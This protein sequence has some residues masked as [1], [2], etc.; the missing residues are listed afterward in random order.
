MNRDLI[1]LALLGSRGGYGRP[2]G[3]V[4]GIAIGV[5]LLVFMLLLW[6]CTTLQIAQQIG[7]NV[8][9]SIV[10]TIPSGPWLHLWYLIQVCAS[11][12]SSSSLQ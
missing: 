1:R 11:P 3:I 10:I 12:F 5:I 7:P 6:P 2:L 8:D 4:A 9:G